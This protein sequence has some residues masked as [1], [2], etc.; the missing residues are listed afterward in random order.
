[1]AFMAIWRKSAN[2][3]HT[4]ADDRR[5]R[6]T[7]YLPSRRTPVAGLQTTGRVCRSAVAGIDVTDAWSGPS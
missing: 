1:M 2:L 4:M 3:G 7:V 6:P 5:H